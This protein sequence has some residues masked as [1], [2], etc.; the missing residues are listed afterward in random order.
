MEAQVGWECECKSRAL[1][2]LDAV[3]TVSKISSLTNLGEQNTKM[4]IQAL[5]GTFLRINIVC[6]YSHRMRS[7]SKIFAYASLPRGEGY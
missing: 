1:G 7:M 2:L 3:K 5:S 6:G 4:Q